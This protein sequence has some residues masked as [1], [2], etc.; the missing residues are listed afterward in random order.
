MWTCLLAQ[1]K[2]KLLRWLK[3]G[4][5]LERQKHLIFR[6]TRLMSRLQRFGQIV[7]RFSRVAGFNASTARYSRTARGIASEQQAA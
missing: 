5:G 2:K 4:R 7:V 6:F 3:T 1:L